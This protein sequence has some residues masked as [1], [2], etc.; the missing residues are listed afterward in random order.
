MQGTNTSQPGQRRAAIYARVSDKSQA[1]DDKTSLAEQTADMEAYCAERGYTV[2]ARYQEV[3]RGWSKQRPEFQRMLADARA[4]RFDTIVCWKSDRLSRGMY[5]AAALMEVVEAHR[6]GIEA[7][8]D[9]IDMKTFGLMA[10]IGKIE[11][12]NFRERASMGKR[13][14]AKRGRIPVNR[15]PYGYRI[16]EEGAP[17]VDEERAEVI[18]R[19]FRH[20]VEDGMGAPAIAER[21]EADG[22]PTGHFG[23]RWHASQVNRI[24]RNEAYKGTWWYGKARYIS[25]DGGTRIHEQ[26]RDSWIG[27]PFPPLIDDE[28][29]ERA[30]ALRA[31]RKVR[32]SR[33][34]KTFHLLQHLVRC[35]ECGL[36]MGPI[37]KRSH[38]ARRG[39]KRYRYEFDPP[40]R[41]YQCYGSKKP[42][43]LRCREH[44]MIRAERLEDLVWG[45]VRRVLEHPDLI[46]AG[47]AAL[48]G[49]AD[50]DAAADV[51]HAERELA[52]VQAEEDRAIRLYV[53]EKITE[54]QLDHQRRFI[55][56]RLERLRARLDEYRARESAAA[57]Q[58]LAAERV[59]EWTQRVG[60]GL[61]DLPDEERRELL[62]LLLDE[63]T[64]DGQNN[65]TL[66]LAI[67]ADGEGDVV[68]IAEQ[69][70]RSTGCSPTRPTRAPSSG[71]SRARTRLRPCA[72]RTPS[73]RSSRETSSSA[74][75]GCCSR[76]PRRL[77]TPAAPPAPIS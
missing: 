43:R 35:S 67:P 55:G 32:S 50:G 56:E 33:N 66:T 2:A 23:G 69:G 54:Q 10:A 39:D 34:T 6:I 37:A 28:T 3:G 77:S 24:L 4:G 40:R 9:A 53:M 70:T 72:S 45:E 11:L 59:V 16:T 75:T 57:N 14:A 20:S 49:E 7:V 30:Q 61:D 36:L 31:Q 22:V 63:A 58:R 26:P 48:D 52:G 27:V 76:A 64:I 71:A 18:R 38:T 29:W 47:L 1:E 51:A 74:R 8:M 21:L 12:D 65:V 62:N 68:S 41:Y 13:G 73:P 25:A 15:V 60:D 17:A 44:P 5:P 42:H 46:V 19:I